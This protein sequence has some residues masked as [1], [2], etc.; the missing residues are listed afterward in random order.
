MDIVGLIPSFGG[1]VWTVAAFVVALSIIVAVHEYGHYIV[2]R[3]TGIHAEVFSLGFG[4]V[5][6]A[7]TD[8]RGTRWQIAA[9]PLGG[10]VKFLGD[11]DASSNAVDS[12]VMAQLSADERRHTMAG[13]PL[14]ARSATVA[15]GP[16]FNFALSILVF[17]A[18]FLARG[19]ATDIPVVGA[20][21]PLPVASALEAGDRI[22]AVD[23]RPVEDMAAFT[24]AIE[25]IAP[26]PVVQYTVERDGRALT[27]DGPFPFPAIADAVQPQ[28][29]AADVGMRPG[30]VVLA[31]DGVPVNAFSEL[32]AAV[33][34]SDGRPLLLTV[35]RGGETLEVA[36]VPRR[37]DLP[38]AQ[39]G[40]ET[41]WLIGLTGG[42]AF[43]PE[44]R[45][46][47]PFEAIALGAEQ[48]WV[49]AR[50]SLSALWHMVT[51]AISSCNLRGPIG[52]AETS[53]AAAAQG[54]ESF[55]WFVAMLSTAIGLLNLF[56]IPIL[57]GG[58]LVFHAWEAATGRPPGHRAVR[59]LMTGGLALLL[60]LMVF[61][62]TNDL[63]C[64]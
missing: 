64:P 42:L 49:I 47:G 14:W 38:L 44:A 54:I 34:A 62:L 56:P 9:L 61:A 52:I 53:G 6:F 51:G 40:F 57:D 32:R 5:L 7:R 55:V 37:M 22:L 11:A 13:A 60:T 24:A 29:A 39:G 45:T 18:F 43:V 4:P 27:L 20:T 46:P 48:T 58:H 17:T 30:D 35:W 63:F 28:S 33:G 41:R 16:L 15:A 36:L 26:A 25:A 31:I 3:W 50:T 2:G 23:G 12:R 10:Y 59:A 1:L 8:R 19:I 21:K